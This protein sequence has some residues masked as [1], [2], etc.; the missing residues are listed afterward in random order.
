MSVVGYIYKTTNLLN[1]KVYIGQHQFLEFDPC[2]F[3]SGRVILNALKKYGKE[4]FK[5]ELLC[6]ADTV[7]ELNETEVSYIKTYNSTDR[8]IGYN[9]SKGGNNFMKD[10][11]FSEEHKKHLSES[12]KG[13]PSPK[14]NVPISEEQKKKI[15][16][17]RKGYPAWNKGLEGFMK[18]KEVS[19]ETR[20]KM[21][22]SAMGKPGTNTGKKFT[23]E[24]GEKISRSR[25]LSNE[26]LLAGVM[27]PWDTLEPYTPSLPATTPIPWNK[28]L[29]FSDEEKER[30]GYFNRVVRFNSEKI[31]SL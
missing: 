22:A 4:N 5:V 24:H 28:G 19:E 9:I 21:S 13:L 26:R 18:G 31:I 6:W 10:V 16:E 20:K 8:K 14:R 27:I 7:E 30:L 2:Y 29:K 12:H 15:S 23:K 25:K 11:P 17:S 3:G 1:G